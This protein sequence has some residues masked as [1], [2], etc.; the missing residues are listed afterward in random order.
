MKS[1]RRRKIL[2]ASPKEPCG[3]TWLIN[4]LLS[5]GVMTYR[6][7]SIGMWLPRAGRYVLN[8]HN[9]GLKKWLPILTERDQFAFRDDVEVQWTHEW[10]RPEHRRHQTLFFIRDVRDAL[11]S[12]CKRDA[13]DMSFR[14]YICFPDPHTLLNRIDNHVLHCRCWL[15]HPNVTIVRFE[16]YKRDARQ[17]L[18]EVLLAIGVEASD[19]AIDAAVAGSTFEQAA[20]AEKRYR[21]A[22]PGDTRFICRSGTVGDFKNQGADAATVADIERQCGALLDR[23]GYARD[24]A[25]ETE[26]RSFRQSV[27]QLEF[28]GKRDIPENVLGPSE[29]V[30]ARFDAEHFQS[31]DVGILL[32]REL[33][34]YEYVTLMRSVEECLG[35]VPDHL[36]AARGAVWK[37]KKN[38]L[39]LVRTIIEHP[40]VRN[41]ELTGLAMRTYFNLRAMVR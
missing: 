18:V 23:F 15:D 31:I 39:D 2:L 9:D 34:Y 14:E 29:G 32:R 17:T 8:P 38:Y 22:H 5:L 30:E 11:F 20:A 26:E 36:R 1:S 6:D 27:K 28:F 3:A 13:P 10:P 4:C 12:A 40:S 25:R 7:W 33:T 21:E 41:W 35:G 19:A 37:R 24:P 16:D